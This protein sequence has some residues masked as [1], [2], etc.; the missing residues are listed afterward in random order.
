M[1]VNTYSSKTVKRQAQDGAALVIS[2]IMLSL[3]TVIGV[4]AMDTTILEIKMAGNIQA[5][6]DAFNN[7]E[8]S[9]RLA[10]NIV[11][12][13][14]DD[15][16]PVNFSDLD[17]LYHSA[18]SNIPSHNEFGVT[19]SDEGDNNARYIVQYAGSRVLAGE[20]AAL[21]ST[22]GITGSAIHLFQ[23][24]SVSDDIG[25]G[26]IQIVRSTYATLNAP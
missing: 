19:N 5:E 10:E 3:M 22:G 11:K 1:F 25:Q 12:D 15:P 7:A 9:L 26:A 8:S 17:W 16:I 13:E 20:S 23:I 21:N 2:L 14:A 6:I 18:D 24:D 4:A